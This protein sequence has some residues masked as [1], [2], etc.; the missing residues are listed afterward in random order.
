MEQKKGKRKLRKYFAKTFGFGLSFLILLSSSSVFAQETC[1]TL[2]DGI[3]LAFE[4]ANEVIM[5]TEIKQGDFEFAY[6]KIR[7]YKDDADEWQ[8]EQLEQRGLPRPPDN[9][10]EDDGEEPAFAF[11]CEAHELVET[12]AGWQILITEQDKDSPIK[13]WQLSFE[14]KQDSFVPI[15]IAGTIETSVLFIPFNGRFSTSFADW[16]FP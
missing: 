6:T 7:L 12:S 10:N 3:E 11:N 4:K 5:S 13:D 9:Q 16:R 1:Q 15:E 14:A 8:S 2:V